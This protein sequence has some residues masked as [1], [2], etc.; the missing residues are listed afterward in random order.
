V[1]GTESGRV[2]YGVRADGEGSSTGCSRPIGTK[3][4]LE[5]GLTTSEREELRQLRR[6]LKQVKLE[7]EILAKAAAW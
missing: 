7:R 5:D 2:V 4:A 1:G 6:E 3:G